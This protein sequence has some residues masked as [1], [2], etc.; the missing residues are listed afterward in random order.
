MKTTLEIKQRLEELRTEIQKECISYGEIAEIQSLA[1]HIEAGDVELLQWA[2]VE[3]FDK[4]MRLSNT[5]RKKLFFETVQKVGLC[6]DGNYVSGIP[7]G[8]EKDI[9]LFYLLE[10]ILEY[11]KPCKIP[12]NFLI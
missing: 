3:E 7:S 11:P 10:D 1:K 12:K 2:G 6:R 5:D 9:N 4:V 8:S